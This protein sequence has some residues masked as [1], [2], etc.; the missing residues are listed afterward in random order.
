MGMKV[1]QSFTVEETN[2]REFNVATKLERHMTMKASKLTAIV[3]GIVFVFIAG[4]FVTV[5]FVSGV[6]IRQGILTQGIL[7][8]FF[9]YIF[10]FLEQLYSLINFGTVL[11]D[12]LAAGARIIKLLDEDILIK[13]KDWL[14]G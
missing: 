8:A 6:L 12:S 5:F 9:F 2:F 13:E 11:Q 1:I 10:T 3:P 7:I 14:P 4:A